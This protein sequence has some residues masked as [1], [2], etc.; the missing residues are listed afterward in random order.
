M[1]NFRDL[2]VWEKSH[3]LALSSYEATAGFPKQ[4]MFGLTSHLQFQPILPKAV[5]DGAMLNFTDFS[6]SQ[7]VQPVS[8]NITCCFHA[9]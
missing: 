1:K 5:E 3:H 4:E 9:I 2:K 8:W 6:K 7:W